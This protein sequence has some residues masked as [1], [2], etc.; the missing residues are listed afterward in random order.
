MFYLE[1]QCRL[2]NVWN[3]IEGMQPFFAFGDAIRAAYFQ[4]Q[5][6]KT[7]VRITDDSGQ[8][9]YMVVP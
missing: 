2:R 4:A 6:R 9:V 3:E 7:Q 5:Q 8:V 1:C